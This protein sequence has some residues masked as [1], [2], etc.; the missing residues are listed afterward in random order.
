MRD[1]AQRLRIEYE[2]AG[3]VEGEMADDPFAQFEQW[4]AGAVAASIPEPNAFV[5][6][7]ADADG[8]PSA[9]AVLMK[10]FGPDGLVFYTGIDSPKS[11][12][13]TENPRAAATF[14]WLDLHR[15]IRF[16]GQVEPIEPS[17]ADAYFATRP[18]G[19][20]VA[21]HV[22]RQSEVVAGREQLDAGF[23]QQSTQFGESDIPRPAYWGGWRLRPETVEF[24]QGQPNRFHDRVVYKSEGD[25]WVKSRLS[26]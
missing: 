20:Q 15:Q 9:R 25:E 3:L 18:R 22:S 23:A 5:L 8:R 12:A 17:E 14:V 26:P 10:D 2:S 21:A 4:M 7:T 6:A 11:R 19:A 1:E 13:M 24:W 16:E